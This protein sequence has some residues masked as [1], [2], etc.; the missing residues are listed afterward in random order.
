MIEALDGGVAVVRPAG[1]PEIRAIRYDSRQVQRGDLFVAVPGFHTDG[2][3]FAADAVRRGAFAVVSQRADLWPDG[4]PVPHVVVP[5]S[6]RALALLAARFW[7]YPARRLRT[8]GI[9]GT[10][11]KTTTSYLISAVLEA[12]GYRTGLM[13]TVSFKVGDRQWDNESR[14]T[15]PEAPEIQELLAA[16]VLDGV[17]Y[18]VLETTSHGLALDRVLGCEF[19]VGVLTNLTGDHLDYHGTIEAYRL[20]KARLFASLGTAYSKGIPKTAIINLDDPSAAEFIRRSTGRVLTYGLAE[21]ATIQAVEVRQQGLSFT[22]RVRTQVGEVLLSPRLVGAFNVANCLAAFAAG[23]SQEVAP[24][25]LV[26]AIEAVQGV[27][28]RMER[29][30]A[31]QPFGVVVDYAHTPDSLDKVLRILRPLTGGRLCAVFGSAGERDRTKR[32]RM[33]A[34][35]AE[36]ADF[37]VLTNEDPRFEDEWAI[38]DEIA[39]GARARGAEEGRQFLRIA[40]RRQAI[41]AALA[42]ARPGDIVLLAGKGHEGCIIVEDRK[43]P[44]DDRAVAH[45]ELLRLAAV[46]S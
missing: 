42:A 32:P 37:F 36:L 7:G 12:A 3:R 6:R 39:A 10:D 34:I 29:I 22:L 5:D 43:E 23:F 30:D 28:G 44:W 15:T 27:P 19:D 25:L 16:M 26:Q 21:G 40:D 33:G 11:G 46:Q 20:A 9:T 2:H 17:Q 8:I 31:G 14:Q 13:G 18:A 24:E 45:E 35:A 1:D 41:R 4:A 38:I